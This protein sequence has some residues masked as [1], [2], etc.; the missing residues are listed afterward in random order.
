[1]L[2]GSV[3]VKSIWSAVKTDSNRMAALG[4]VSLVFLAHFLLA[5]GFKEFYFDTSHSTPTQSISSEHAST[6]ASMP[7]PAALVGSP[8]ALNMEIAGEKKTNMS[9]SVGLNADQ[10]PQRT[11]PI[12]KASI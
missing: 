12:A 10:L 7:T 11:G 9:G 4:L 8:I 3:L 6:V 5:I 2:S 1:M